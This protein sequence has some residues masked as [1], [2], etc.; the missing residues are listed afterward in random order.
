[1]SDKVLMIGNIIGYVLQAIYYSYF[2]LIVKNIKTKR[3]LFVIS[4]IIEY[5]L[6]K[7][8]CKLHY[9]INFELVYGLFMFMLLIFVYRDKARITDIIT[10]IISLLILGVC[11]ILSILIIGINIYSVVI[12]NILPIIFTFLLRHKLIKIDE[13]YDNFWN[14]HSNSKMLKSITIRGFSSVLTVITFV[15]MHAWLIYGILLVRR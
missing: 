8:V 5:I 1:M 12:G 7:Y 2:L 14:R 6:L 3:I 15:L 11:S 13:F 9:T 4:A 10:Y